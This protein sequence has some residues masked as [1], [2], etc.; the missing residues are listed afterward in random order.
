MTLTRP[1]NVIIGC[2]FAGLELLYRY[3]RRNGRFAP[4]E[5]TVVEP[6]GHHEYIPLVHE[7]AGGVRSEPEMLFDTSEFCRRIGAELVIGAAARIDEERRLIVLTDGREIGYDRVVIAVG[8]VPDVPESL[9]GATN[10]IPAKFLGSAA[11]IRR[12]LHVLRVGGASVQRVVVVGAGITGVEWSA[13][14]AAARVDGARLATTL[15]CGHM[16]ILPKFHLGVARRTERALRALGV[17]ILVSRRVES[18]TAEQVIVH[19]G[20]GI[21]FDI[22][23]WAGGV[24]PNPIVEK[25]GLPRT[26][27]GHIAVTPRLAVPGHDG[28]YAIGDC[29]R[30]VDNDGREWPTMERAIE[31]IWQGAYLARRFGSGWSPAD[32][33]T[34]RLRRD[35]FYGISLGRKRGA[36][37]YKHF[38]T[39]GRAQLWVR[40]FLQWG[41][42]TR[43]RLVAR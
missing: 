29:A 20:I 32:G 43:F 11:A 39:S 33:P 10:V 36:I 38:I 1:R 37:I 13:E 15:I 7:V 28:V 27:N 30:I 8:S 12:R 24:R 14:L 35:Y 19:G 25:L 21:P 16:R 26:S 34:H 22:V 18:I 6:L 23:V 2:S 42:Y 40:R 17:E 9:A 5:A 3:V 4:G 41:Y 31:A